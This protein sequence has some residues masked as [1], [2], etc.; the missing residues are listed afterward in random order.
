MG[1]I[2]AAKSLNFSVYQTN[3][4]SSRWYPEYIENMFGEHVYSCV[5]NR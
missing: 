1:T 4:L 5:F 3:M 2:D